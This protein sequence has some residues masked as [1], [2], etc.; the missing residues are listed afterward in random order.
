MVKVTNLRNLRI[1]NLAYTELNQ[2]MFE[3]LCDDL[4]HLEHLDISGTK[5]IDL[6][7]LTQLSSK[8][9]SLS[10]S[11]S[12][13]LIFMYHLPNFIDLYFIILYTV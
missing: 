8:L 1:L 5:V 3:L 6:R 9:V 2:T 11:V 12:I 4:K 13:I 7:P 10:V